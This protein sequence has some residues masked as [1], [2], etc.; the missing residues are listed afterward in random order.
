MRAMTMVCALA[1]LALGGCGSTV[2]SFMPL[3][4]SPRPLAARS[5]NEVKVFTTSIPKSAFVEVGLLTSGNSG[6]AS[7]N[8]FELINLLRV[9]AA[10]HGCD[11]LVITGINKTATVAGASATESTANYRAVCAVFTD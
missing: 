11:A 7:A 3:N 6:L 2:T 8:D 1:A 9:E 4:E 5:V 10:K